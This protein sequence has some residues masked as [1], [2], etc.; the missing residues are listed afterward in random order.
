[1]T[2]LLDLDL[3]FFTNM[4]IMSLYYGHLSIIIIIFAISL[5]TLGNWGLQQ[6]VN[7]QNATTGNF[8]LYTSPTHGFSIEHP[9]DWKVVESEGAVDFRTE[10]STSSFP[11]VSIAVTNPSK[12]PYNESLTLK[13]RTIQQTAE[14]WLY[15]YSLVGGAFKKLKQYD[16]IIAGNPGIKI[17]Y[18]WYNN[19]NYDFFTIIDGILYQFTYSDLPANVPVTV[20][21]ANKMVESF[22]IT[23]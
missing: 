22:K 23:K 10:A 12:Y 6:Q 19:Y 9:S 7:A 17:E 11:I 2:K 21:L 14:E 16:V 4:S 15:F 1:M 18:L 20:Q 3:N 13:N 8:K 5:V